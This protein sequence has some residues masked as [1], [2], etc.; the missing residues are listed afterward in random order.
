MRRGSSAK[1]MELS[2]ERLGVRCGGGGG[3]VDFGGEL[4]EAMRGGLSPKGFN[5]GESAIVDA[6]A[7]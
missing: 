3:G 7:P 4:I 2:L 1:L 6:N 5:V